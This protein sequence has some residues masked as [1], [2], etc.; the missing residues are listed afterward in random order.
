MK[1][2]R[3]LPASVRQPLTNHARAHGEDVDLVL[4]RYALER[5][6]YRLGASEH[7]QRFILKG[8]LLFIFWAGEPYRATRDLDLLGFGERDL[9]G[10]AAVFRALCEMDM[11]ED[12]GVEFIGGSVH[13]EP[14]RDEQGYPG[15]RVRLDAKLAG[16][17]LS[18]RVD[19][20]FGDAVTPMAEEI[21]YPSLLEF[22]APRVRAYPKEAVVAE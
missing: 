20:G 3:N 18:V 8:A 22:P 13:A 12:D 9:G 21:E 6:L 7:R 17:R 5:L 19:I 1:R 14:M 11:A 10:L 2:S 15:A 16:A 4:T